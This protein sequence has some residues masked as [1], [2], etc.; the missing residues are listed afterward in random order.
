MPDLD[1]PIEYVKGIGPRKAE[2]LKKAFSVTT[3]G[4]LILQYPFRYIDKTNITLIKN[5]KPTDEWVLIKA[6]VTN[7]D[8]IGSCQ[9]SARGFRN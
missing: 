5:I 2:L 9:R 3:V 7:F 1:Q 4:D 8:L 6:K